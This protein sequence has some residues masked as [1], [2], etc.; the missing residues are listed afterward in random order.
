M[1][2]RAYWKFKLKSF[3]K[4]TRKKRKGTRVILK[5]TLYDIVIVGNG[6][7][8][9]SAAITACVLNN[10]CAVISPNNSS[11]LLYEA[12]L[13]SNYPGL[14]S[15]KGNLLLDTFKSQ[16]ES[17]GMVSLTG[18]VTQIMK[19]DN[20]FMLLAGTQ[21]FKSLAV[22][23]TPGVMR[24][25]T[26]VGEREL[27]GNGVS[28]CAVC[29]GHFYKDK[30]IALL[31][32]SSEG[33]EEA[34][35]LIKQACHVSYY[36]MKNHDTSSLSGD[37]TIFYDKPTSIERID[38]VLRVQGHL[39]DGVFISRLHVRPDMLL[40]DLSLSDTYIGVN[41]LME[42]NIAGVFAAGDC[43]GVPHQIAKAVGEGNIAAISASKYVLSNKTVPP[44]VV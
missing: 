38:P 29:D 8:G 17:L 26:L 21:I 20:G 39:Y 32:Y 18:L 1:L 7:A 24:G 16:A 31:S 9:L 25:N 23:L 19:I 10:S 2:I 36:V 35:F 5:D 40:P 43:T 27:L 13:V 30:N 4:V 3:C 41:R 44:Y 6:P 14:P 28:Y 33:I 22:I 42:T 34:S 12:Q 11:S 15:V 37:V